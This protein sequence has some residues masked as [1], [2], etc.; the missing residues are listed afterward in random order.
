MGADGRGGVL[1]VPKKIYYYNIIAQPALI[2]SHIPNTSKQSYDRL[3]CTEYYSN[4]NIVKPIYC[5]RN[6]VKAIEI[7]LMAIAN[8]VKPTV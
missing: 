6:I 4:H 7:M 2:A 3:T 8:I 1:S 5:I